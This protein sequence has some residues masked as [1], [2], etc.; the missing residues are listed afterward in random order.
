MVDTTI[1]ALDAIIALSTKIATE[2]VDRKSDLKQ[3]RIAVDACG[4]ANAAIKNKILYRI[5][6]E[7]IA[8]SEAK[9]INGTAIA[10]QPKAIEQQNPT[11]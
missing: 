3:G 8:A 6:R 5:N 1:D 4:Q 11:A 9:L 7:R 10:E 2:A